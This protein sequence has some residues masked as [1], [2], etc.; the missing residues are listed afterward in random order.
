V[1]DLLPLIF[2]LIGLGLYG[3]LA[4]ADFGA[5]FWQLTAGR[6]EA[7][8]DLRQR[9]HD[10][11]G[12]VWEANHVW[13]IFVLTVF[14]TAYP[15]AFGSIASTL[16]VALLIA[17]VGIIL[18]GAAYALRS[19][20]DEPRRQRM[21]DTVFGVSSVIA[22]FALG[23]AV[24]GIASGRVPVGNARGDAISSW[25]NP[26]SILIGTLAVLTGIYLAAVFL[27]GDATRDG[28]DD[29]AERFRARALGAGAVAG[30]VALGGFVVLHA[31]AHP[32]YRGLVTGG[33]LAALIVSVL[34]GVITLVLV[35]TR[36]YERA[37]FTAALAVAA[38][39]AGWALAQS[40]RLLPGLTVR[41]AASPHDTLVAVVVAI[42]AG[43][44]L[45][46]PSLGTL[47]S[48]ALGG[49]LGHGAAAADA[50]PAERRSSRAPGHPDRLIRVAGALFIAGLGFTNV[51]DASWAH[52]IGAACYLG[53]VASAFRVALPSAETM[54]ED[55]RN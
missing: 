50:P 10:S 28:E 17:V 52:L 31:D 21:I 29:L 51:A 32:L 45:L 40:P 22:P 1:L 19:G 13:L 44:A 23:A 33:G 9:A 12:P 20:A 15:K 49:R 27:S 25:I 14:W 41:Q 2:A 46:L 37:R 54:F 30:M 47:F 38:I 55:Q 4:G 24:G 26:T 48:L 3:V 42:V 39:V 43:G 6:G 34:A 8:D 36:R 5:G 18:R 35:W 11:M 53:F 16:S 7:A